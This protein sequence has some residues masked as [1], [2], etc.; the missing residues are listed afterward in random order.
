MPGEVRMEG[1]WRAMAVQS[2][3][4]FNLTG[5][6]SALA[7]P[8]AVARISIFVVSTYDTDYVLVRDR[9]VDRAVLT[10]RDAG[11]NVSDGGPHVDGCSRSIH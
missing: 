9:D 3:L 7:V 6:L 2:P 5:I 10:L 1:G 11:H 8:L 4:E